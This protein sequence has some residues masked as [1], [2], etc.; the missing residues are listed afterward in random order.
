MYSGNTIRVIQSRRMRRAENVGRTGERRDVYGVSVG[1]R[2]RKK[3]L[4]RP[5]RRWG[6]NI[7]LSLQEV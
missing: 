7:K 6:Y 3:P 5:R 4:V 2:E 1:I